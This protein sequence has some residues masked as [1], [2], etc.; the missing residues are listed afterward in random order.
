MRRIL[1]VI[2]LLI[3]A[4]VATQAQTFTCPLMGW[5]ATAP[6]GWQSKERK[7]SHST[8]QNLGYF[9]STNMSSF[10]NRNAPPTSTP[11][12]PAATPEDPKEYQGVTISKTDYNYIVIETKR[13]PRKQAK[14]VAAYYD[15]RKEQITNDAKRFE[16]YRKLSINVAQLSDTE[17]IGDKKFYT[18]QQNIEQNGQPKLR[19]YHYNWYND[20]YELHATIVAEDDLQYLQDMRNIL[21]ETAN[22]IT[23][24]K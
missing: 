3:V 6:T 12:P 14:D 9:Q 13:I 17:R 7:N 10:S 19:I 16:Q 21:I 11:P 23:T 20:K 1:S 24:K 2:A 15:I 22:S 18:L 4:Q 8:M 5:T